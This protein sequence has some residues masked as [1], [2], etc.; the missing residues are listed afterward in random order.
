MKLTWCS[1]A[2]ET[3]WSRAAAPRTCPPRS[4]TAPAA[5]PAAAWRTASAWSWP[6]GRCWFQ[7]CPIRCWRPEC[8]GLRPAHWWT[9][10]SHF[11]SDLEE[12]HKQ[13]D[14]NKQITSL[15]SSKNS[16]FKIKNRSDHVFWILFL[17]VLFLNFIHECKKKNLWLPKQFSREQC[18]DFQVLLLFFFFFLS[19]NLRNNV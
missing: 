3:S 4:R 16:A 1:A 6:D 12:K 8:K 18:K 17:S 13:K 7:S 19:K 14:I 11:L 5:P 10:S 15:W 2:R 9:W